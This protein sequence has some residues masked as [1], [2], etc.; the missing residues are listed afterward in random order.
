MY[1]SGHPMARALWDLGTAG[2]EAV[3][4]AGHRA[5]MGRHHGAD[6]ARRRLR[7]RRRA[8]QGDRAAR[9]DLAHRGRQAVHHQRRARP[10]REHLPPGAGPAGGRTARAPRACRCSWCPSTS[11]ARTATLG[12]RNGVFATNVEHKMGLKASTTCEL[13]FGADRPGGRHPGRRRA[14][15][16]QADVQDHRGRPDDGRHQGHRHLVHR[17]PERA[18]LRQ[19]PGA[20]RRPHP[21]DG[22]D[23]AAGDDHPPPRRPPHADAAEGL[24]RGHAGAGPVHGHDPGHA[25][26]R[27]GA[28][29]HRRGRRGR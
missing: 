25:A 27:G 16:H 1:A 6:R 7:R 9:R 17:L 26:D 28:G 19:Q 20:G 5:R 2:A 11:S 4:A 10:G 29:P 22:Q 8:D 18:G 21:D 12:E 3:R 24:R 13:T 23:R 15:R 14:R